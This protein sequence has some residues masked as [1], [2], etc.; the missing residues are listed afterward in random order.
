MTR[1]LMAGILA[2]VWAG[3]QDP[4]EELQEARRS[5]REKK[6]QAVASAWSA[7]EA[8]DR[9]DYEAAVSEHKKSRALEGEAEALR[10]KEEALVPRVVA[11]LVKDLMHDDVEI[12]ERATGRLIMIGPAAIAPLQKLRGSDD[13]EVRG[14][15]DYVLQ[16]L[17]AA[18]IDEKGRL[19]QW[20]ESARASSEYSATS[21][22]A[23]QAAGKPDTFQAGDIP[24]AWASAT[25]DGGEE[26]L[27]LTYAQ[28]VRP[29]RVR[30]HETYNPGAVVR[31][32]AKDGAGKWHILWKGEDSTKEAPGWLDV[33]FEAPAFA[34]R[35]IRVTID[36]AKVPG[37]NE[38]DAVELIGDPAPAA[39]PK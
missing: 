16:R 35:E 21:W 31:I 12:R 13:A 8:L 1:L 2:S 11:A 30:V 9:A 32:E 34:T 24:T 7:H 26:W 29:T 37:W 10:K 39:K 4:F 17:R 3:P 28:P 36:A 27:E 6:A 18:D 33:A 23:N 20:A 14:R 5:I 38:I 22:C 15:A 19:R 25:S